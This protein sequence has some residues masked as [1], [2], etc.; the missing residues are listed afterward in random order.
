MTPIS[1]P[2]HCGRHVGDLQL[3]LNAL[4]FHSSQIH[5]LR[6]HLANS[7]PIRHTN[8]VYLGI[9]SSCHIRFLY[10]LGR[11]LGLQQMECKQKAGAQ[12]LPPH[13]CSSFVVIG[14]YPTGRAIGQKRWDFYCHLVPRKLCS[15]LGGGGALLIP[16]DLT[17]PENS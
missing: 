10:L 1:P 7:T 11:S 17:P 13:L 16:K 12:S 4:R 14:H 6:L 15:T 2:Q 8:K 9:C 3:Q 5:Q